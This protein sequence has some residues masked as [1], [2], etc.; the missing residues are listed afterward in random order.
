MKIRL[1]DADDIHCEIR[2]EYPCTKDNVRE[3]VEKINTEYN[4]YGDGIDFDDLVDDLVNVSGCVDC[5]EYGG[6]TWR[7]ELA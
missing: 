6:D 4:I 3:V 7:L 1:I 2:K 5:E